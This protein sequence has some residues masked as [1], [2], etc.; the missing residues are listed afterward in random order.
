LPNEG[1][2][3]AWD[4]MVILKSAEHKELAH[5]FIDFFNREEV[6]YRNM[7]YICS[8][9]PVKSAIE[10]MPKEYKEILKPTNLDKGQLLKGFTDSKVLDCYSK[11]FDLIKATERKE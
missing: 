5:R 4:E 6:A 7:L 3:V 10:K 2:T 9:V 1:F 8:L 11:A